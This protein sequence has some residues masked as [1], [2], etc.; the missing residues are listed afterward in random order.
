[1]RPAAFCGNRG[2]HRI[3]TNFKNSHQTPVIPDRKGMF[4]V[5]LPRNGG[6]CVFL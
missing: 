4:L 5:N 1:L 6:I 3:N 2:L